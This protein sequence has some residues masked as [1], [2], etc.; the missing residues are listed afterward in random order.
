[1]AVSAYIFI[2]ISQGKAK[3]VTKQIAKIDGVR[4]V[5][6]VTG[7]YDAIARIE[8]SDI[9]T[10]GALVVSKIQFTSGVIRTQTNIVVD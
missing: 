2:E 9:N 5:H 4:E 8:A 1:M 7:P 6:V 3:E 10:L